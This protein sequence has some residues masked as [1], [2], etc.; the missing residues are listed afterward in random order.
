MAVTTTW[1]KIAYLL[2][3]YKIVMMKMTYGNGDTSVVAATGLKIIYSVTHS[4]SSVATK[5]VTDCDVSGGTVTLTVTDP[6]G[7]A[8]L[9]ITAIGI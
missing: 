4:T 9:F 1:K 2:G 5:T 6:L 3:K 8:Y 7:T